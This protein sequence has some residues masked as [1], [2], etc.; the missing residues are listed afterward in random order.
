MFGEDTLLPNFNS[1]YTDVT[2][3]YAGGDGLGYLRYK[4]ITFTISGISYTA[5][6]GMMWSEWV[7]SEYNTGGFSIQY[8]SVYLESMP[9]EDID[10]NFILADDYIIAD[11][12]YYIM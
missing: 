5:L 1:D 12:D 3:A 6:D 4:T 8:S 11:K 10:H 7:D 9:I 2:Y